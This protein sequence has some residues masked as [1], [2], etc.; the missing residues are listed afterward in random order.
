LTRW[1]G[2]VANNERAF[3]AAGH[4]VLQAPDLLVVGFDEK[5]HAAAIEKYIGA[6]VGFV[7]VVL[8]VGEGI[9]RRG[10]GGRAPGRK[11]A[12]PPTYPRGRGVVGPEGGAW[13]EKA[14]KR[15]SFWGFQSIQWIAL[16]FDVALGVEPEHLLLKLKVNFLYKTISTSIC[17]LRYSRR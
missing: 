3:L 16:E 9:D 8:Q 10:I 5:V 1:H 7:R 13:N 15:A 12:V 2:L 17:I 4:G 11:I 6:F 14:R